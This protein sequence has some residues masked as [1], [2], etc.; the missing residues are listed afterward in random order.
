MVMVMME[1]A[2]GAGTSLRNLQYAM[3]V[4]SAFFNTHKSRCSSFK[5]CVLILTGEMRNSARRASL[6]SVEAI[7][8]I[9]KG[10]T[11]MAA[12]RDRNEWIARPKDRQK[13]E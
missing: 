8:A 7:I 5:G 12:R 2:Q 11:A 4:N 9:V 13:S 3:S 1:V 10:V 6:M